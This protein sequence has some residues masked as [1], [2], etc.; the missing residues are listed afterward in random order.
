MAEI[1]QEPYTSLNPNGRVP[2]LEDP[3]TSIVLWESGAIVEYLVDT[4]DKEQKLSSRDF[5]ERY[6]LKQ[7][8]YFQV[9]STPF[10]ASTP[11]QM[12]PRG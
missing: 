5:P 10:S 4:Y 7:F 6:H 1:K 2:T 8:S 11:L 3:N 12:K 9:S